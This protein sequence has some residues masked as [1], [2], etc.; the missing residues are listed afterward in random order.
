[1]L[2]FD[3]RTAVSRAV[4]SRLT[5]EQNPVTARKRF[6]FF[7]GIIYSPTCQTVVSDP[8]LWYSGPVSV[9]ALEEEPEEAVDEP[10]RLVEWQADN[11]M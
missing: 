1:M 9:F 7:H 4:S 5:A 8:F 6:D 11:V 10:Q 2:C 3:R